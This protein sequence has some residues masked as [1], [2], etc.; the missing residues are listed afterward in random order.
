MYGHNLSSLV[1]WV[2]LSE[3][4][5]RKSMESMGHWHFRPSSKPSSLH[6][7]INPYLLL[8]HGPRALW[9][10]QSQGH[11]KRSIWLA[12]HHSSWFLIRGYDSNQYIT[13]ITKFGYSCRLTRKTWEVMLWTPSDDH[14]IFHGPSGPGITMLLAAHS[15]KVWNRAESL[16]Q[17]LG[18]PLNYLCRLKSQSF[19]QLNI[20]KPEVSCS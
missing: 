20:N 8:Q 6:R 14:S 16:D 15:S 1:C 18:L 11:R 17:S 5:C 2:A 19:K 7:A 10:Y 4:T 12:W 13:T 3:I 9:K